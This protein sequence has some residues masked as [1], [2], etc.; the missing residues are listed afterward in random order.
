MTQEKLTEKVIETVKIN[1][2]NIKKY[3][4]EQREKISKANYIL[5]E[6]LKGIYK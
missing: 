3:T 6:A 5:L 2:E 1:C 4:P